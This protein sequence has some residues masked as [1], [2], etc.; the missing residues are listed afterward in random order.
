M[1]LMSRR[2]LV[3]TFGSQLHDRGRITAAVQGRVVVVNNRRKSMPLKRTLGAI[4]TVVLISSL[5]ACGGD[6]GGAGTS[7]NSA[8]EENLTSRGPIT[9]VQG[10]DNSGV[11]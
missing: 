5:A 6:D 8:F 1:R 2:P 9:Y 11:A 3:T 10:K 7:D 4:S